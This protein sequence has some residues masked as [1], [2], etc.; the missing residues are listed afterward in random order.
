MSGMHCITL[1]LEYAHILTIYT[2]S[3]QHAPRANVL[4][5]PHDYPADIRHVLFLRLCYNKANERPY[6]ERVSGTCCGILAQGKTACSYTNIRGTLTLSC[7]TELLDSFT[8]KSEDAIVDS[9][10]EHK[11]EI[12]VSRAHFTWTNEPTDGTV[13]PSR[14]TFRLRVDDSLVFKKG[15]FNL[16]VGP[17]GSGK[18]S[19]LMALLSEMHYIP[20][21]PDSWVS[22]PREGGVAYAAQESWVQNETIKDNILFGAPYD[23]D[24]YK[25]GASIMLLDHGLLF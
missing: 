20:L 4:D 18:T 13:T 16:I 24:R 19:V 9:S 15:S 12:G 14:Q 21:G 23:E 3:V 22:L 25:K 10:A 1:T 17:T 5:I 2:S 6:S 11:D 8:E 7:K